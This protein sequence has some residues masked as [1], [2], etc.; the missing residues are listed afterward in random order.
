MSS[1][2]FLGIGRTNQVNSASG[3]LALSTTIVDGYSPQTDDLVIACIAY[4]GNAPFSVPAGWT[5]IAQESSGN[6]SSTGSAAIA[7]GLMAYI[8]WPASAPSLAF[9]RTG[10][11]VA[12][13]VM[14]IYR[15]Q[16][17]SSP[18]DDSSSNTLSAN[19]V[20]AT[21]AGITTTNGNELLV[22][23]VA[24]G[25]YLNT[26]GHVTALLAATDPTT[27]TGA[28][29]VLRDMGVSENIW[30]ERF[31]SYRAVG[32]T[33][34][35]AIADAVKTTA[36]ATGQIQATHTVSSKHVMIVASFSSAELDRSV[37]QASKASIY[38]VLGYKN[39]AMQV[40][41]ASLYT[42][43]A[44]PSATT[45]KRRMVNVNYF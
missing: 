25:A 1:S 20:T 28:T 33:T 36:G 7:S 43:L 14:A 24:G 44:A 31:D 6:T 35:L 11:D 23:M 15:G 26:S 21:T 9:T 41:K 34:T 8:K 18:K 45:R 32:G 39:D 5:L 17:S 19:S 30:K 40:A 27:A 13:G 10:G 3:D 38:S 37:V 29:D 22:A 42:I 2:A 4:R 12:T 16:K